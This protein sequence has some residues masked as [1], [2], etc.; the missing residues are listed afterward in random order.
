MFDPVATHT[1]SNWGKYENKKLTKRL[2]ANFYLL[3]LDTISIT[4]LIIQ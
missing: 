3:I 2:N 1:I 4:H